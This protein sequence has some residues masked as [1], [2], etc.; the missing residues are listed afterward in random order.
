MFFCFHC[1]SQWPRSQFNSRK[2]NLVASASSAQI[3]ACLDQPSGFCEFKSPP[4]KPSPKHCLCFSPSMFSSLLKG[5]A[6]TKKTPQEQG[7]PLLGGSSHLV[8]SQ[9]HP[10]LQ[11]M[12]FG[13]LEGVPQPQVLGTKTITMLINHFLTWDDPPST[14]CKWSYGTPIHTV[15]SPHLAIY[16]RNDRPKA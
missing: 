1:R 2:K 13:H 14:R 10:H 12:E 6:S 7:G 4:G 8:S 5:D 3:Q 11:A 9:D 15:I 16:F